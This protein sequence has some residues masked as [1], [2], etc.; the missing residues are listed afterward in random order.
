MQ[1]YVI[2]GIFGLACVFGAS[3][4]AFGDS[5]VATLTLQNAGGTISQASGPGIP[6]SAPSITFTTTGDTTM[7]VNGGMT[8]NAPIVV[9]IPGIG[10]GTIR[11]PTANVSIERLG[12]TDWILS[13]N[14]T[15]LPPYEFQGAQARFSSLL[16]TTLRAS[17]T[18]SSSTGQ[19]YNSLPTAGEVG[20]ALDDGRT[21]SVGSRS[22]P[23]T[24]A[25]TVAGLPPYTDCGDPSLGVFR[26]N[27]SPQNPGPSDV[28][29]Y[30]VRLPSALA[31][32]FDS[33]TRLFSKTTVGE[34]N[35]L[36]DVQADIVIGTDATVLP[37]YEKTGAYQDDYVGHFGPLA[38]GSYLVSPRVRIATLN[39]NEFVSVCPDWT[40]AS[41]LTVGAQPG[42]TQTTLAIEYYWAAKDHYFMTAD[43]NEI[44]ALD[45]GLFAGWQRTGQSFVVYAKGQSNGRGRGVS[46]YYGLPAAG[47]D[48]HFYTASAAETAA[49]G[50][51]PR[52]AV[53][54][55]EGTGVFEIPTPAT[56]TGQCPANTTNVYRLWN[57]RPDSNHRYTTSR[58]IRNQMIARGYAPEGYGPDGVIMCA[59]SP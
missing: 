21:I 43:P 11:D 45:A 18:S 51:P 40:V 58:A 13:F 46:R 47:L 5:I 25:V 53:W 7:L 54:K 2:G 16:N 34:V 24:F 38:I 4:G 20:I 30:W 42:A 12:D 27:L 22:G 26:T 36:G 15:A 19:T 56:L 1:R 39:P 55:L 57:N 41:S 44:A 14:W 17:F 10:T 9:A 3:A 28:I 8:L 32:T 59:P 29:A 23:A 50:Q 31:A 37:G 52:L 49:M 35:Q 6:F 33:N 48:S